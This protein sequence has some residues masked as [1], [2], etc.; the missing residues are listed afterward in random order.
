MFR[1][2]GTGTGVQ[3]SCM[4]AVSEKAAGWLLANVRRSGDD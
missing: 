2:G 1:Y 4:V 3:G